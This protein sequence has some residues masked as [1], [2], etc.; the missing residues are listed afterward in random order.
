[1]WFWVAST[2]GLVWNAMGVAAFVM[3]MTQDVS[4]LPEPERRFYETTP[5]WA[6]A[7]FAIAVFGGV[8]GCLALLL[9]KSWA[10]T[11]LLVCLAGIVVQMSHSMFVSNGIEVFGEAGMVLPVATFS[12]ALL[13]IGFASYSK[14]Q[15]WLA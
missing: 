5:M 4:A 1:M 10:L 15:G 14:Q 13:L 2:L 7:A 12:I 6:T 11:M 3:Q 8:L 9:R